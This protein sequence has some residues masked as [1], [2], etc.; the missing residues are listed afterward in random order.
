MNN[1]PDVTID[2]SADEL[3]SSNK[4]NIPET[5]LRTS[6]EVPGRVLASGRSYDVGSSFSINKAM[7]TLTIS[8]PLSKYSVKNNKEHSSYRRAETL[9]TINK[10]VAEDDAPFK[11]QPV[12]E[13]YDSKIM[14]QMNGVLGGINEY[15]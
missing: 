1:K 4:L 3:V 8:R 9:M 14:Q 13:L 7:Q 6:L 2:K 11:S 5:R 15:F 10:E 12:T